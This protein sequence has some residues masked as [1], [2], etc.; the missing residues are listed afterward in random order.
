MQAD[1]FKSAVGA[2]NGRELQR[3]RDPT[4]L[5][6]RGNFGERSLCI[7]FMNQ[8]IASVTVLQNSVVGALITSATTAW[9]DSY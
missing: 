7:D 9:L 4:A 3:S 2:R 8:N 1:R 5:P 6:F